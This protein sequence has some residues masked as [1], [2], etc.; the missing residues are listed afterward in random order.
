MMKLVACP[1]RIGGELKI[2]V[3]PEGEVSNP[4]A[5]LL[6]I[7]FQLEEF[8]CPFASPLSLLCL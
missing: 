2:V 6:V 7:S 5:L 4:A 1:V 3:G 8:K